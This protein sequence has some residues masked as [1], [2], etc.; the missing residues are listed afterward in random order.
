MFGAYKLVVGG[1]SPVAIGTASSTGETASHTHKN[2]IL[3]DWKTTPNITVSW[4]LQSCPKQKIEETTKRESTNTHPTCLPRFHLQGFQ[5]SLP[6][7][8][9]CWSSLSLCDGYLETPWGTISFWSRG[10]AEPKNNIRKIF[11]KDSRF[12]DFPL[13]SEHHQQIQ[14]F[15]AGFCWIY[16]RVLLRSVAVPRHT[17]LHGNLA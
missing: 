2:G 17:E 8:F 10:F 7:S 12:V 5:H 13:K 15:C 14:G 3:L 1:V 16:C 6:N 9:N 4:L 11:P